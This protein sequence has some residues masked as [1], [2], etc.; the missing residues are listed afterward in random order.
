M[1]FKANIAKWIYEARINDAR[2]QIALNCVCLSMQSVFGTLISFDMNW[3]S[4][5]TTDNSTLSQA[6]CF[7]LFL[8]HILLLVPVFLRIYR[9]N[10]VLG[11][12]TNTRQAFFF[13]ALNI[14]FQR[15]QCVRMKNKRYDSREIALHINFNIFPFSIQDA[16]EVFT[17]AFSYCFFLFFGR[18]SICFHLHLIASIVEIWCSKYVQAIN[19]HKHLFLKI[20][21]IML[22]W[23]NFSEFV[24]RKTQ[25]LFV[26]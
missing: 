25:I 10:Q 15:K 16:A 18:Q 13:I 2:R 6:M 7:S 24:K 22:C 19:V 8:I 11:S 14:I 23:F 4:T 3:L 5:W 26:L 21:Y 9:S 1:N 12:I 20:A 17:R